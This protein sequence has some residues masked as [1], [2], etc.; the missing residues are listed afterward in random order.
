MNPSTTAEAWD[1]VSSSYE[2]HV[3]PVLTRYAARA[4]QA[5]SLPPGSDVIDIATGP[6]TLA[7]LAAQA[8]HRV[9]AVDFSPRMIAVLEKCLTTESV[10][11][12]ICDGTAL[13]FEDGRF[14][15]GFSMFGIMLFEARAKGLAEL[16]RV[17]RPHGGL[18]VISSWRPMEERPLFAAVF[19]ALRELMPARAPAPS[20]GLSSVDG[21]RGEMTEAGFVD[22]EVI[23][24][25]DAFE[26]PS[27]EDLWQWFVSTCAPLALMRRRMGAPF[28]L[29]E[30]F[31]RERARSVVGSG[32]QRVEMPGFVALGRRPR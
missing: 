25:V 4:L 19:G 23:E 8:G 10:E 11:P 1:L 28:A 21:C 3:K 17:V 2:L 14:D 31:L 18:G 9:V 13:P 27:F 6:G 15:A 30:A 32:P 5:S 24:V 7:M 29:I 20:Q 16:H 26:A 22:V 12:R